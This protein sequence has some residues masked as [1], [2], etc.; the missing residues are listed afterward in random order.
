MI[1]L[2]IGKLNQPS[3]V[4]EIIQ[5]HSKWYFEAKGLHR[6]SEGLWDSHT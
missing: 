4:L 2:Q 5:P 1:A 3:I 6:N